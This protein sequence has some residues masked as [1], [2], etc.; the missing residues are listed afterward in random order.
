[1]GNIFN[2]EVDLTEAKFLGMKFKCD[3]EHFALAIKDE[4]E[5]LFFIPYMWV[6]V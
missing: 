2:K 4:F 1:M 6:F 5:L 3:K